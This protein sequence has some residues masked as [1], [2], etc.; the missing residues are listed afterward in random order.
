MGSFLGLILLLAIFATAAALF[1]SVKVT[2]DA[3]GKPWQEAA[4]FTAAMFAGGVF[5]GNLFYQFLG[6]HYTLISVNDRKTLAV[7][8]ALAVACIGRLVDVVIERQSRRR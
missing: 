5:L 2:M 1:R 7:A 3:S 4:P 6:Q 8:A